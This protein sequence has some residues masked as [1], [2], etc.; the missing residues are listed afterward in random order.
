VIEGRLLVGDTTNAL[1]KL[2]QLRGRTHGCGAASD[3]TDWITDCTA[4]QT[5]RPLINILI[6]NLA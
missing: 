4:Q 1:K 2:N 5:I 3:K 6:D